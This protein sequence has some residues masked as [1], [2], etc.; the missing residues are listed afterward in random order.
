MTSESSNFLLLLDVP[1]YSRS[2]L[3]TGEQLLHA[4]AENHTAGW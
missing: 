3:R 4:I 1:R 2:T